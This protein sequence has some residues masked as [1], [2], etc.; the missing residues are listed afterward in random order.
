MEYFSWNKKNIALRNKTIERRYQIEFQFEKYEYSLH[1]IQNY[2]DD[3]EKESKE[4]ER[5][6]PELESFIETE[7]KENFKS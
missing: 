5:E 6:L 3:L 4:T 7:K 1:H 2:L